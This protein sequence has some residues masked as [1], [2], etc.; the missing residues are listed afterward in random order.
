VFCCLR[1]TSIGSVTTTDVVRDWV[2]EIGPASAG[3]FYVGFVL[4]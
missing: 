1:R 3:L 2:L 4:G